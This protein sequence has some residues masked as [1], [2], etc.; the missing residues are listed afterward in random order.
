[1][2]LRVDPIACTGHGFCSELLP[3]LIRL[4]DWGYPILED[5]PISGELLPLVRRTLNAC[6]PWRC[7]W[8]VSVPAADVDRRFPGLRRTRSD[9]QRA[10]LA[11]TSWCIPIA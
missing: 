2:R 9:R 5:A 3:E 7:G 6:R 1:M 11:Q 8:S 10:G 4:D